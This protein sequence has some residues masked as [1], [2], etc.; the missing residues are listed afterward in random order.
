MFML[1]NS[2]FSTP[3]R[4]LTSVSAFLSGSRFNSAS[5]RFLILSGALLLALPAHAERVIVDM[6]GRR[7]SIAD[8]I[9]RVYALG[10]C[11]PIVAAVAPEKLANNYRLGDDA[12]RF[13]SPALYQDKVIPSAGMRLSDEE[14]L[15]MA[16][17]LIVIEAGSGNE[18]SASL[19]ENRL[20]IPVIQVDQ[21]ILK[22]KEAFAFLGEVLEHREQAR[23]LSDFVRTYLDPVGEKARHIPAAERR[24]VYYAEGPDGLST[25]PSGSSHTQVLDF[26]GAVNVARVGNL[27]GE[28]MNAVSLEQLYLWQPEL[29]LVWTPSANRLTT[30]NAITANPLWTRVAAVK[31][32]HVVQIPWLP[33]S[34]FDR[35]PGS[36]RILGALWL[37]QLLYPE[38]F[39]YDLPEVTQEYFRKF[40]HHELL[41][42][43]AV[44]LLGLSKPA[45]QYTQEVTK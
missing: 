6:A 4:W 5:I 22:Y 7:V 31:K 12:K 25:N 39:K 41:R 18:D 2:R 44:Y 10:H 27:P 35:P 45:G 36:N 23:V 30:W 26:V 11:I 16:P 42:A 9:H 1:Q 29:I 13:L 32:G 28:G 38:R 21:D 43:D 19:L 15:K 24:R 8:S 14:I 20:H 17:D 40:Y 33:F 37:A 34:W 3:R